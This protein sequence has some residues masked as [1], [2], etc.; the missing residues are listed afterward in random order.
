MAQGNIQQPL[1]IIPIYLNE[2]SD[3]NIASRALGKMY[4]MNYRSS[5]NNIPV[6]QTAGYCFLFVN[7]DNANY[8]RQI[9]ISNSGIYTR[10]LIAGSYGTWSEI[11]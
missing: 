7:F 11:Q 2:V 10:S 4:I 1:G 9:A 3:L 8:G 5:T 6:A